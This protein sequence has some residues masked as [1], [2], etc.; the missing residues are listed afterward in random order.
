MWS[1]SWLLLLLVVVVVV[2][3]V[4]AAAAELPFYSTIYIRIESNVILIKSKAWPSMH[5]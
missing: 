3:V 2:V 5:L 4:A 1:I